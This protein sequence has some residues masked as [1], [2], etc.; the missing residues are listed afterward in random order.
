MKSTQSP[1]HTHMVQG[2]ITNQK[3]CWDLHLPQGGSWALS[4]LVQGERDTQE[5]VERQGME[6]V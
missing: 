1:L 5:M 4:P 2:R 3:K 6:G